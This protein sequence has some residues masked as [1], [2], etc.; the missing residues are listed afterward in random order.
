MAVLKKLIGAQK[1]DWT[2]D[3]IVISANPDEKAIQGFVSPKSHIHV[4]VSARVFFTVFFALPF[5]FWTF[6]QVSTGLKHA[7][8]RAASASHSTAIS[9]VPSKS[10]L[11]RTH[12]DIPDFVSIPHSDI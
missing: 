10:E 11:A 3:H 12:H 1:A 4:P 2:V 9:H 6:S 5:V 8:S 7:A